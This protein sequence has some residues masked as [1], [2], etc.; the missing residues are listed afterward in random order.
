MKDKLPV[1]LENLD[2]PKDDFAKHENVR[3]NSDGFINFVNII[4]VLSF[5]LSICSIIVVLFMKLR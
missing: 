2:L 5:I 1:V 4:Y 3:K